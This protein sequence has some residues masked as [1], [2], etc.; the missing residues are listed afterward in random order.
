MK[1]LPL[2]IFIITILFVPLYFSNAA[3][4]KNNN[5]VDNASPV[6]GVC[7][8]ANG[9]T[10]SSMPTD[11]LC[12]SGSILTTNKITT[13]IKNE[14]KNGWKWI[15]KSDNGG[16]NSSLCTALI[17]TGGEGAGLSPTS[18][19]TNGPSDIGG[20]SSKGSDLVPAC[21]VGGCGFNELM[22]LINKVINFLLF[23]I[24][25]PLAALIFAY[26]GFLLITAGGD[27]SKVTKAKAIIRNLLIGFVI[28]LA[29]WLIV[30]TI[31]STLGFQGSFLTR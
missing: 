3:Q 9:T 31:L 30:N 21:P 25:M 16:K 11:N 23:K 19:D 29:A 12:S 1:K 13:P 26:A 5:P 10:V 27:P 28:A 20:A 14:S 6:N 2:F 24:A 22:E 18:P 15:C 8:S 7:G 4:S 17:K